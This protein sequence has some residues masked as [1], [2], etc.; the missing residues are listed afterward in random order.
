MAHLLLCYWATETFYDEA[1][2]LISLAHI[3]NIWRIIVTRFVVCRCPESSHAVN[4][5]VLRRRQ[6]QPMTNGL[7]LLAH[8]SVRQKLNRVSSVQLRRSVRVLPFSA[9]AVA[10]PAW[11]HVTM[12]VWVGLPESPGPVA[13]DAAFEASSETVVAANATETTTAHARLQKNRTETKQFHIDDKSNRKICQPD[14]YILRGHLPG[15]SHDISQLIALTA[16]THNLSSFMTKVLS[17]WDDTCQGVFTTFK[18]LM[19]HFL[20]VFWLLFWFVF[21]LG[22]P[23]LGRQ[24]DKTYKSLSASL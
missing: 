14:A 22:A 1:Y 3:V 8:W 19:R 17:V 20:E 16:W 11:I 21:E 13:W 12:P 4:G 6:V 23:T 9:G 15:Y 2:C 5:N 24:T 7:D 10:S 18:K